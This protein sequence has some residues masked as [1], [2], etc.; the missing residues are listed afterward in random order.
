MFVNIV[1][2]LKTCERKTNM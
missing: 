1:L 2:G